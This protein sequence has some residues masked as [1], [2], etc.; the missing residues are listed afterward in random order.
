M[1][2]A[3]E[4]VLVFSLKPTLLNLTSLSTSTAVLVYNEI[5]KRSNTKQKTIFASPICISGRF[6]GLQIQPLNATKVHVTFQ[7]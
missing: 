5:P 7:K 6:T 4:T 3:N 2:S 1:H